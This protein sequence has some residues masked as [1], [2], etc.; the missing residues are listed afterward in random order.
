MHEL[1]LLDS[2]STSRNLRQLQVKFSLSFSLPVKVNSLRDVFIFVMNWHDIVLCRPP[3]RGPDTFHDARLR[4]RSLARNPHT[5][6]STHSR[7]FSTPA[8][9]GRKICWCCRRDTIEITHNPDWRWMFAKRN[10]K[11]LPFNFTH[12]HTYICGKGESDW[13][14]NMGFGDRMGSEDQNYYCDCTL[15][16]RVEERFFWIRFSDNLR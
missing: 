5:K 3:D 2:L 8:R 9:R 11:M 10:V 1:H 7:H 14:R 16:P 15:A 4:T 13:P 12:K 6:C